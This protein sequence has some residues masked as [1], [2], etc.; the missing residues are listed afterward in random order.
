MRYLRLKKIKNVHIT[1][2]VTT[3]FHFSS[4][5]ILE[6]HAHPGCDKLACAATSQNGRSEI[7]ASFRPPVFVGVTPSPPIAFAKKLVSVSVAGHGP[8]SAVATWPS[9][10]PPAPV[11]HK[12]I[13]RGARTELLCC[14]AAA[15]RL[16]CTCVRALEPA[17]PGLA[18]A[19]GGWAPEPR[20]SSFLP[21][22]WLEGFA[23]A[24]RSPS[25]LHRPLTDVPTWGTEGRG[26]GT[27]VAVPRVTGRSSD[28][29]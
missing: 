26:R 7:C 27:L 2:S 13:P 24:R 4:V 18:A 15:G 6:L 25:L 5:K 8:P 20:S 14:A 11:V 17:R 10:G 28:L 23:L 1:P 22:T 19:M 21:F 12:L 16:P 3:D 9:Y 29:F